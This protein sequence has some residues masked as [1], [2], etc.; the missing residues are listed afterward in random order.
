MT[1]LKTQRISGLI[2]IVSIALFFF[3]VIITPEYNNKSQKM[4]HGYFMLGVLFLGVLSFIVMFLSTV[5]YSVNLNKEKKKVN[6]DTK[7]GK[8]LARKQ[9]TMGPWFYVS[10]ALLIALVYILGRRSS[11]PAVQPNIIVQPPQQQAPVIIQQQPAPQRMKIENTNCYY[12]GSQ[13]HCNTYSY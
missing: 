10:L 4:F 8:L 5:I 12:I 11:T 3:N 9:F 2:W 1:P 13:L 7:R 6:N